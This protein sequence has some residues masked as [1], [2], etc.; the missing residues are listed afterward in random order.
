M[1]SIPRILRPRKRYGIVSGF[2]VIDPGG[3]WLLAKTF[4]KTL[5]NTKEPD[6]KKTWDVAA[7]EVQARLD[8]L[9]GKRQNADVSEK[10]VEMQ[11]TWNDYL[12]LDQQSRRLANSPRNPNGLYDAQKHSKAGETIARSSAFW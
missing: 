5:D 8:Y 1:A 2:T 12:A 3:N 6:W 9:A 7:S 4:A 10:I 11:A